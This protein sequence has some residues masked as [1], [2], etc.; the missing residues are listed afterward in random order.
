MYSMSIFEAIM[1]ICF[2][3]AWPVSIWKSYTSR[4]NSGKSFM[5]LFV[6]FIGYIAGVTHKFMFNYDL[7]T[8]LYI[9]NG[10]LIFVDMVIFVRNARLG[11]QA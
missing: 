11:V 10:F 5:F 8:Y 1:L 9:L 6:A 4:T 7:V 2:G 3:V